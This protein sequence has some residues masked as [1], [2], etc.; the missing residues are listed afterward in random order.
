MAENPSSRPSWWQTVPGILTGIAAII[1]A[2]TG[3][4]VV[5][6]RSTPARPEDSPRSSQSA[7]AATPAGSAVQSGSQ[8]GGAATAAQSIALPTLNQVRFA[9]GE[10]VIKIL[11]AEIEPIDSERRSLKF[12]VRHTNTSRYPE[13]F[14]SASYR[15]IVEDVPRAPTNLLDEVVDGNSAKEGEVV[16]QVPVSVKA[17]VLQISNPG[18]DKNRIPLSLP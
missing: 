7:S 15:L 13:N 3:L 8:A 5:L 12:V 9:D 6:N 18:N 4:L 10:A 1:T 14:W 2:A 16:F 11:S 17:V